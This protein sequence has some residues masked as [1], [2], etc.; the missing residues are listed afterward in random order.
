MNNISLT[1]LYKSKL[2]RD[3]DIALA[4][5]LARLAPNDPPAV[6]LAALLA[7]RAAG[8]G[9]V[10]IDLHQWAG[11]ELKA[12]N[13]SPPLGR[14]PDLEPWI[15]QLRSSA[16]VA[17]ADSHCPLVC[18]RY[19]RVYLQR[20]YRHEQQLAQRLRQRAA[21][22]GQTLSP[23]Q[24][25]QVQSLLNRYFGNPPS[26]GPPDWQKIAAAITLLKRLC[27]ISGAPGTGKTT[28]VAKFLG[29]LIEWTQENPLRIHLCAP[30]GKAAARLGASLSDA[31]LSM[32]CP[33]SV[34]AALGKLDTS[35]IHRLLR[36]KPGGRAF[37]FN[38]RNPLPT[39]VV[40]VDEAS[41]VDLVLMDRLVQAVPKEARLIILG[42]KDQL[43]S[44]EAGAVFGDLCQGAR[45]KIYS[46]VMRDS[47]F[48]LTG[49]SL[50]SAEHHAP[51]ALPLADCTVVLQ[52]NYR[53]DHK[54]GIGALTQAINHGD[55]GRIKQLLQKDPKAPVR[56]EQWR[57][58][59]EFHKLLAAHVLRG[60]ETYLTSREPEEAL[61][62]FNRFMILGALVR[63][64]F[65]V[66]QLNETATDLL[67]KAGLIKRTRPWFKGRPVMMTRNSYRT[68]L[69]N[70][71]IGL[72]WPNSDG[73]LSVWFQRES[74]E[75]RAMSPQ[76]LPDHQTAFAMTVH[77]SQGSEFDSAL[78]VLPDQ[79]TPVL[80]RE[81]IYTGCSRARHQ[82]TL[83]AQ[84]DTIDL[85][86]SRT[87]KRSSGLSDAL[88]EESGKTA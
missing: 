45:G 41:M 44:V 21:S 12:S 78:L 53:F 32:D 35:T 19:G 38:A 74:G 55:S 5:L 75:L 31:S 61:L 25:K 20:L 72:T 88:R 9:H 34:A 11:H 28:T 37:V 1:N 80:N 16:M 42:D 24:M 26:D 8:E 87:V 54:E 27:I 68:G 82:L 63:G 64:P 22:A 71:D 2:F 67:Q 15:D 66:A 47:I 79:D 43:A 73:R 58:P 14:C 59:S 6:P 46:T 7:S 60:Y 3:I 10:C 48:A 13:E 17:A 57:S 76:R 83:M 4:R 52:K 51:A 39:D 70:G 62:H 65:G 33:P 49:V 36:P 23:D 77:K 18:D 56:W 30:T 84:A 85:A 81:L 50:S 40:V 86:V 69:F 29:V